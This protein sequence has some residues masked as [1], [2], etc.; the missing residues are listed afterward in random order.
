MANTA[1]FEV[2][3]NSYFQCWCAVA[4]ISR[5]NFHSGLSCEQ[6]PFV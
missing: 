5:W 3:W 6:L 2:V 1:K 4:S